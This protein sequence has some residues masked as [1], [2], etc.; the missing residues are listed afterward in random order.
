MLELFRNLKTI[1]EFISILNKVLI[2]FHICN[3]AICV[4]H[5]LLSLK[6]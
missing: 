2:V 5:L 4:L 3:N 6:Y 1:I